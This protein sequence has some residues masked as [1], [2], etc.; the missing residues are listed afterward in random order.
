MGLLTSD[1]GGRQKAK[2]AKW[3]IRG[4]SLICFTLYAIGIVYFWMLSHKS[5]TNS[6]YFSENALLPGE[7][8]IL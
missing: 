7:T 3:L 6:T 5:F 2:V 8:I 1:A 4:N